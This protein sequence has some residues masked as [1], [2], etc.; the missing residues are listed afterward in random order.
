[1]VEEPINGRTKIDFMLDKNLF[2]QAPEQNDDKVIINDGY[3]YA[4]EGDK[5][6][7][8]TSTDVSDSKYSSFATIYDILK[9]LPGVAVI[10]EEVFIRGVGTTGSSSPLFVINGITVFSVSGIDPAMVKSIDILKGPAATVY[11]LE[12]GNGVILIHTRKGR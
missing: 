5:T 4:R 12:G 9:T 6:K 2:T 11:G 8:V 3:G 1:M 7:P 10:G